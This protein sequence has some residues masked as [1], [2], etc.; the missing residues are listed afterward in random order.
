MDCNRCGEKILDNA[1]FCR[2]CGNKIDRKNN[3]EE[4]AKKLKD[5]DNGN[6]STVTNNSDENIFQKGDTFKN[7]NTFQENGV[8]K[9]QEPSKGKKTSNDENASKEHDILKNKVNEVENQQNNYKKSKSNIDNTATFD[10]NFK[11]QVD[12]SAY[13]KDNV[14]KQN[15]IRNKDDVPKKKSKLPLIILLILAVLVALGV[16][17]RKNIACA[18]YTLQYNKTVDAEA[19]EVYAEKAFTILSN[20]NTKKMLKDSLT[21]LGEKDAD[22]AEKKLQNIKD[23]I[24]MNDYKELACS[25]KSGKVSKL[26]KDSQYEDALSELEKMVNL[27][28]DIRKDK[29]YDDIMLNACAKLTGNSVKGSKNLLLEDDNV[30]YGDLSDGTFDDI[31]EVKNTGSLSNSTIKV[32]L[33]A[34]NDGKYKQVDTKT[35]NKS[36]NGKVEGIY[37]CDK[38]DGKDKKALYMYYEGNTNSSSKNTYC[39]GIS[40]IGV[41][42]NKLCLIANVMGNRE[43]SCDDFNGDDIYE[44]F[45]KSSNDAGWYKVFWDGTLPQ[46]I[47]DENGSALSDASQPHQSSQ[48]INIKTSDYI[49]SNSN[50]SYLTDS[51]LSNLNKNTLAFARNEIFARHG[52][53]FTMEPFVT[54]FNNKTWYNSNPN[55]NGDDS[56]LN[57]Y[58]KANYKKIQEWENK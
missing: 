54:Y 50:T 51:Q 27:G 14:K 55:F 1:K 42:D 29:N 13:E 40:V 23:K 4:N 18:Y 30:Y 34:Y 32:N 36:Y 35:F 24:T 7:E 8:F 28:E 39:K 17:F 38:V 48:T 44:I 2:K 25:I 12:S 11:N 3:L 45:S 58:E 43:A 19:K 52:Y 57:Q 31:I 15:K 49:F 6:L 41:S 5:E 26:C 21:E 46:K 20:E 16:V 47:A 10:D 53:I 37:T 9:D 56:E 22:S 33:Y